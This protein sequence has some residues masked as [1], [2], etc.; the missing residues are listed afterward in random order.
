ARVRNPKFCPAGP[1]EALGVT[2][3]ARAGGSAQRPHF[4]AVGTSRLVDDVKRAVE[5]H[6]IKDQALDL[7]TPVFTSERR[8]DSGKVLLMQDLIGLEINAP[9]ACASVERKIGLL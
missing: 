1:A 6:V 5:M 2:H 8:A 9:L 3:A 7:G 4:A